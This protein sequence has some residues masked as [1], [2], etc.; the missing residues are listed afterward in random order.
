MSESTQTTRND[1]LV[2]YTVDEALI[3]EHY[4]SLHRTVTLS[5]KE[6]VVKHYVRNHHHH[7]E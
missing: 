1:F 3:A 7:L 4:A 6:T 2:D 5:Q